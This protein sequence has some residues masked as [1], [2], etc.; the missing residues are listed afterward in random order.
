MEKTKNY[1]KYFKSKSFVVL[2]AFSIIFIVIRS[3]MFQNE[4]IQ[5][6]K[7]YIEQENIKNEIITMAGHF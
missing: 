1:K 5:V 2:L 7:I 3:F 6:K 4:L